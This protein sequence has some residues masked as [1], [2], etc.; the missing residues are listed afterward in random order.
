MRSSSG[1]GFVGLTLLLLPLGVCTAQAQ[2]WAGEYADNKFL[3]GNATFQLSIEQ[4]GRDIQ[5]SFDAAHND[6]HGCAPEVQATAKPSGQGLQFTFQDSTGNTGTGTI[7]RDGH[8][9][10]VSLK[11]TRVV[12]KD[13]VAFYRDNIHLKRVTK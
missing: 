2:S 5:V 6:G 9:L 1:S 8:D 13:C 10:V 11:L 12:A 7:A 3:S 4:Q